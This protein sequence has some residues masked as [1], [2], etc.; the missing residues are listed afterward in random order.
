MHAPRAPLQG[1]A[2]HSLRKGG[3]ESRTPSPQEQGTQP[4][5][6]TSGHQRT[7]AEGRQTFHIHSADTVALKF[8]AVAQHISHK[9]TFNRNTRGGGTVS[10]FRSYFK[11]NLLKPPAHVQ[12]SALQPTQAWSRGE[13][14]R[15]GYFL[16]GRQFWRRANA[17]APGGERALRPRPLTPGCSHP[18][19]PVRCSAQAPLLQ[20]MGGKAESGRALD[21]R[22]PHR[23][24]AHL[25]PPPHPRTPGH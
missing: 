6:Q 4:A 9:I 22:G 8:T 12:F 11:S 10:T 1:K 13:R 2:S 24:R 23:D 7:Q 17:Q 21:A 18:A 15:L 14:P 3:L 20:G 25:S 16:K 5:Q 19:G